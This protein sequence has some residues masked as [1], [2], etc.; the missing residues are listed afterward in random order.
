ME[1]GVGNYL[2][3]KWWNE[4]MLLS[5]RKNC[6]REQCGLVFWVNN[7]HDFHAQPDKKPTHSDDNKKH[8]PIKAIT[9]TYACNNQAGREVN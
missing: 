2:S 9:V 8:F 6:A 7:I 5:L 1:T 3:L 4:S